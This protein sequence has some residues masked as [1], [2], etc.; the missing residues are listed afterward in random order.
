V[1]KSKKDKKSST[2]KSKKSKFQEGNGEESKSNLN[3]IEFMIKP[4]QT[5]PKIDTAKWPL[6]LKNYDSLNVRTGHYTPIAQ[7]HSPLAR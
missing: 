3:D 6:L 5:G 2:K 4:E 7:G 1:K